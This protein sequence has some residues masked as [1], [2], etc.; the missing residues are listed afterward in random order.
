MDGDKTKAL[1]LYDP[2]KRDSASFKIRN[3]EIRPS[4]E[5]KYLGVILSDK[6]TFGAHIR[7]AT[8]KAEMSIAALG[9][10]MPNAGRPT[11]RIRKILL[12]G[13]QIQSS[14]MEHPYD[15]KHVG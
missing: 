10:L 7:Y 15:I 11:G 9:K 2:R 13:W 5:L 8:D 12:M 3:T 14:C 4:K 1:T 6:G